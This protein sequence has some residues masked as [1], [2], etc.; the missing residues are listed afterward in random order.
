MRKKSIFASVFAILLFGGFGVFLFLATPVQVYINRIGY[1]AIIHV[2]LRTL[3][4]MDTAIDFITTQFG[5][6]WEIFTATALQTDKTYKGVA[7]LCL[8]ITRLIKGTSFGLVCIALIVKIFWKK[9]PNFV[10]IIPFAFLLLTD[11]VLIITTIVALVGCHQELYQ[12]MI[13]HTVAEYNFWLM[14]IREVCICFAFLIMDGALLALVV[15]KRLLQK[16][17]ILSTLRA[18]P[19]ILAVLTLCI[20]LGFSGFIIDDTVYLELLA[21]ALATG[22]YIALGQALLQE[23]PVEE[24]SVAVAEEPTPIAEAEEEEQVLFPT[25]EKA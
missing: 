9:M 2:E 25:I 8:Q 15:L 11:L 4:N 21:Y 12:Q 3:L 1:Q 24:I 17:H 6:F 5:K 14:A 23:D 19:M 13:V 7:L 20:Y 22:A 16:L 18:L 10:W